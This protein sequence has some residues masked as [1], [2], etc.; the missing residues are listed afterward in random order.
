MLGHVK[1]GRLKAFA[2]SSD[3]RSVIL[4]D[5]P[6][7][8]ESEN[9]P[10]FD[11]RAWIGFIAPSGLPRDARSRLV[12]ECEKALGAADVKERLLALGLEPPIV[13]N[14]DLAVY[15]RKQGDRFGTIARQAK[16]KLD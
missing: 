6:T 3:T 12:S 16:I 1:A 8:A 5:I 13:P 14:E 7:A 2:V 4:P 11:L 15:L 10:D 9:L